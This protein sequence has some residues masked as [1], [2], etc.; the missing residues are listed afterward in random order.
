[1]R[2]AIFGTGGAGGYFGAHLARAG[3]EV[4]FIAR[5]EHLKAIREQGLRVEGTEGEILV[6]A[7]ATDDPA[8]VGAV[9]AVLLGVKTWQV[10]GA[11]QVMRPMLAPHTFVVPLQNGVEAAANVA[12]VIGTEHVTGGLCG[13]ISWV[14]RPGLIRSIGQTHFIKFGELDNR[15]SERTLQL[16]RAFEGAG[17]KAEIPPD[18]EAAVWEKFIFVAPCGGVGA[19]ARAP[20]G[21]LRTLPETRRMLEIGVQEIFAVARGHRVALGD[22]APERAMALMD[23]LYPSASTSLQRDIVAGRPSELEAWNGAVVRLGREAGVPTPLHE[24]IYHSLLASDLRARGE[25]E[26]SLTGRPADPSEAV[27]D[28]D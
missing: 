18:I 5:G 2:I 17:V 8:E 12:S 22:G 28:S 19:V 13:T 20:V 15:Q 11:A 6:R 21:V 3:E 1:M 9:D 23:A 4:V 14:E 16:L 24:F 10:E 7:Q 25:L 26:F 27:K